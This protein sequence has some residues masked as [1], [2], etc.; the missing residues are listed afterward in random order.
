VEGDPALLG[1]GTGSDAA[2]VKFTFPA[3]MGVEASRTRAEELIREALV[4]LATFAD[5]AAPLCAIAR[6]IL[7]RRS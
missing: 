4:S 3:L 5:R 7:E 1:K 2:R 6:H